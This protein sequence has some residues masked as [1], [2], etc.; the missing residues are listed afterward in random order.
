MWAGGSQRNLDSARSYVESSVDELGLKLLADAQT[1][2][3][4]LV[5]VAPEHADAYMRD[6]PGSA[7]IG[8]VTAGQAIVVSP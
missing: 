1:S 4:L 3:G 2:G 5:A 6:V 8:V 7:S